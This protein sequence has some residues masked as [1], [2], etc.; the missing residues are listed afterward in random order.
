[1]PLLALLLF[2]CRDQWRRL[3][4]FNGCRL[5]YQAGGWF[6]TDLDGARRQLDLLPHPLLGDYFMALS[7]AGCRSRDDVT[8]LLGRDSYSAGSWRGLRRAVLHS[9][10]EVNR[11][12][13]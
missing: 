5:G 12:P 1:M 13:G 2:Y 10:R 9:L 4:K 3:H 11:A 7:F 6:I 8:L